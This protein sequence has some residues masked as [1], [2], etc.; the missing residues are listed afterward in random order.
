MRSLSPQS[1]SFAETVSSG[2]GAVPSDTDAVYASWLNTGDARLVASTVTFNVVDVFRG[3]APRSDAF[4]TR[5]YAATSDAHVAAAVVTTP[6]TG[7]TVNVELTL[8]PTIEKRTCPFAP[9]SLS[10]AVSWRTDTPDN[11]FSTIVEAYLGI[12]AEARCENNNP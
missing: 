11:G 8:P 5:M 9:R 3:G 12:D 10:A 2:P 6:V 4:T 7:S 1:E